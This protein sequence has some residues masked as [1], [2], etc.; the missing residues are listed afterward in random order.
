MLLK[1]FN[2]GFIEAQFLLQLLPLEWW[3]FLYSNRDERDRQEGPRHGR[4]GADVVL[5]NGLVS[6]GPP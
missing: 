2:I 5:V 1:L 3:G 4:M 6:I